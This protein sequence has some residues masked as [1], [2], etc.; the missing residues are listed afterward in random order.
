MHANQFQFT[1]RTD[2][3]SD[4]RLRVLLLLDQ[5]LLARRCSRVRNKIDQSK[6]TVDFERAK[7]D[8]SQRRNRT[9]NRIIGLS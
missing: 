5:R 6:S 2:F 7:G 9:S 8:S 1:F 4:L 3:H